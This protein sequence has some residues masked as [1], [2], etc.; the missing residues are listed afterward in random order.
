MEN[1]KFF[2]WTGCYIVC[3]GHLSVPGTMSPTSLVCTQLELARIDGRLVLF[4]AT[5]IQGRRDGGG[6]VVLGHTGKL[7]SD[8]I[9]TGCEDD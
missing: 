1:S 8:A 7:L 4:G 2:V 3:H 5:E 6:W 9:W